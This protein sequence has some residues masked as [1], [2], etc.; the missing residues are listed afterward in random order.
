MTS[1]VLVATWC[2]G[3]F[4]VAEQ[5]YQRE[6]PG[7]PVRALTRD[8]QGGTLAIVA[9]HTLRR[10]SA[11]GT[12]LT[13]ATASGQLSCCVAS[14]G[15]VYVGTEDARVLR[16]AA[17]NELV[18]LPGFERVAGRD[19]WYAGQALVDGRLLGPPLGVRSLSATTAGALLA[20]VHVGGIP[21]STDAG[22]SWQ[23][24]IAID[25]DVHEVRAHPHRANSVAAAAA[26]GLCISTDGGASWSVQSDGLH[27][28]YCSAVAFVGNDVLVAASEGHF[29]PSGRI[30]R[31]SLEDGSPP[32]PVLDGLPEWT[33][34]IVDTHCIDASGS[35]VAFADKSGSIYVSRDGGLSWSHW[36][37]AL[38]SASSLLVL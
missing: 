37:H 14:H 25:T 38:P 3:V 24:S 12:W 10:R 8:G 4:S 11:D 33:D 29:A 1:G 28:A 9:G 34:G 22:A 23:P 2:D 30:Y 36:S 21:R 20:N 13:L 16:L 19:T 17:S 35:S 26:A 7:C 15:N 5:G 6:L 18:P 27:A 32:R 31:R